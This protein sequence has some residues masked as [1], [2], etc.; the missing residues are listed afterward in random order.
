MKERAGTHEE[1]MRRCIQLARHAKAQGNTAV[2]CVVVFGGKIVGEGVEQ[3]PAGNILT[4]HAEVLACQQAIETLQVRSLEKAILYSTAEPCFMFRE[5]L[6]R[7]HADDAR[8]EELL[9]D[10]WAA[11]HPE[12]ILN[13]RLEESRTKAIRTR[14]RRAHRRARRK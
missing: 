10:R 7:S 13:H 1:F 9:P 2:G 6:L 14:A 8:L 4:G 3:Q 11:A 5:L 12:A